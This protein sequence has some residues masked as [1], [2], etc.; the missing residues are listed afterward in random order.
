MDTT[1][2]K[3]INSWKYKWHVF[4]TCVHASGTIWLHD[5]SVCYVDERSYVH[6][7][8]LALRATCTTKIKLSNQTT[9]WISVACILLGQ[10]KLDEAE[11]KWPDALEGSLG[12]F[13]RCTYIHIFKSLLHFSAESCHVQ[14]GRTLDIVIAF[15]AYYLHSQVLLKMLLK[16]VEFRKTGEEKCLYNSI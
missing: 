4:D 6:I 16:L 7:Q 5:R 12:K 3:A 15:F 11:K 8:Q 2:Q 9:S 14:F 10:Q 1:C 13:L